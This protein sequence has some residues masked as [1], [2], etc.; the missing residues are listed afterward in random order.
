MTSI[1]PSPSPL[2]PPSPY[3]SANLLVKLYELR[4]DPE[5]REARDWFFTRFHPRSAEEVF[6]IWMGSKSAPYRMVTTYWEMA[7]TFV[8]HGAIDDAMFHAAN[9]EY[10]AVIAKLGP[11]LAELRR[12][13]GTPTYLTELEAL[14]S[15]MP[16]AEARISSF[17][18]YMRRKEAEGERARTTVR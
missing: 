14:V 3:E 16:D 1:P 18:K 10:I 12:L 2:P 13:S 6:S 9:T 7:A 4:R 17:R 11:F 5:L 15:S 8:R